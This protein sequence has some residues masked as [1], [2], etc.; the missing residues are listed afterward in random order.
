MVGFIIFGWPKRTKEF[1]PSFY[2]TCQGCKSSNYHHYTRAR[3]WLTI[4][5][6]P[7]LPLGTADYY[8]TCTTVAGQRKSQP[9][10]MPSAT[11][12]RPR[13]RVSI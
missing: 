8:A 7:I 1:G 10:R 4:W 13:C 9:K 6:I 11:K 5:F 12:K 2:Y 3:R